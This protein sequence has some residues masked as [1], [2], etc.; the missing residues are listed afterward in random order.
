MP[1]R[2]LERLPASSL[3]KSDYSCMA[4][5]EK[6]V[7]YFESIKEDLVRGNEGSYALIRGENFFGAFNSAAAAN[8]EGVNRFGN[9]PFLVKR[10]ER[11]APTGS[12]NRRAA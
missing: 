6:E 8:Q 3:F 1:E 5:L 7:A 11:A 2:Q 10:I 9:Q 12:S 4:N